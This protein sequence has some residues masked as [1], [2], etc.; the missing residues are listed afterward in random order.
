MRG[1][2]RYVAGA[3]ALGLALGTAQAAE[4]GCIRQVINRTAHDVVFSQD[5]GPGITVRP[6]RAHTILYRRSGQ[7]DVAVYCRSRVAGLEPVNQEPAYQASFDTVAV[8][9]RCYV[10][11]GRGGTQPVALNNPRQGDIVV[12]PYGLACP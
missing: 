7:V 10:E 1:W 6:R 3:A 9:D 2:M 4:A 5:G 12:A 8:M 11:A